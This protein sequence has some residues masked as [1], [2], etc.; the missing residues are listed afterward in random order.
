MFNVSGPTVNGHR[1]DAGVSNWGDR[2]RH[3]CVL[4]P[5]IGQ[6]LPIAREVAD[7]PVR[8]LD[9]FASEDVQRSRSCCFTQQRPVIVSRP[10]RKNQ[11]NLEAGE[12][13]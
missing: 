4:P 9:P 8:L 3:F 1:G 6:W 13:V 2:A 5:E 11:Q 7:T 10:R 12:I